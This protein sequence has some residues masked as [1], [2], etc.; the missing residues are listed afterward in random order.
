M[1]KI[2]TISHAIAVLTF[3]TMLMAAQMQMPAS[4]PP[5]G[6]PDESSAW[7]TTLTGIVSDSMCGAQPLTNS[8]SQESGSIRV[9]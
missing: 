8:P 1:K 7:V 4:S 3:S 9:R 5:G 6:N 2:R